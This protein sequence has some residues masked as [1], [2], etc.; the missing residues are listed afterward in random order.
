M[1]MRPEGGGGRTK[2][3]ACCPRGP[4]SGEACKS[5]VTA[6]ERDDLRTQRNRQCDSPRLSDSGGRLNYAASAGA[7]S[8][9]N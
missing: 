2:I 3:S 6:H 4:F 9:S 8:A 5:C 7:Y 1:G